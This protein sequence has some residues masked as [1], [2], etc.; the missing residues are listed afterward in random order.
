MRDRWLAKR[1]AT[2]LFDLCVDRR[3]LEPVH[4]DLMALRVLVEKTPDLA[5]F[6]VQ[7]GLSRERRTAVLR[8]LFEAHVHPLTYHF[9][10]LM[11]RDN[12]LGFLAAACSVFD[13]LFR[14]SKGIL[15]IQLT[16]SHE[17]D[18]G[19][20]EEIRSRIAARLKCPVECTTKR[21]PSLLGG[22]RVQAGDM[23]Y[24]FSVAAQLDAL[25][26]KLMVA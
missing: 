5:A 10:L 22:F 12:R 21:D 20:V 6:L 23:V 7:Y 9:L 16:A 13:A 4:G 26:A 3:V 2:A 17:L 1:Y 25:K 24:D 15:D 14:R 8:D 19:H 18:S 11:E